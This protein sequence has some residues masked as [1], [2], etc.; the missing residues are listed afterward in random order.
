[1]DIVGLSVRWKGGLG[2]SMVLSTNDDE[3]SLSLPEICGMLGR[4]S[5]KSISSTWTS[6]FPELIL[7]WRPGVLFRFGKDSFVRSDAWRPTGIGDVTCDLL[8]DKEAVSGSLDE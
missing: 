7:P 5:S 4:I 8:P 1:M 3:S 2:L 6:S